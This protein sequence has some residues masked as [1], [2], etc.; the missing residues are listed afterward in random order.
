MVDVSDVTE[1]I[2]IVTIDMPRDEFTPAINIDVADGV[3]YAASGV[4]GVYMFED[5]WSTSEPIDPP[6]AVGINTAATHTP[7]IP[8]LLIAASTLTLYTIHL[9]KPKATLTP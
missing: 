1:P 3:I 2:L 9:R 4:D 8:L 6:L 7:T 5:L